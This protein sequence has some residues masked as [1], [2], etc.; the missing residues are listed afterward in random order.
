MMRVSEVEVRGSMKSRN[1]LGVRRKD[2]PIAAHL[3]SALAACLSDVVYRRSI[4]R[5]LKEILWTP[6][7]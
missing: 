1:I 6:T 5:L 4:G 7:A 2:W 3:D